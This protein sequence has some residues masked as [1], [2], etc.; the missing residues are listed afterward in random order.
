MLNLLNPN[1]TVAIACSK[2]LAKVNEPFQ[3]LEP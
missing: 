1:Y 2:L 3:C